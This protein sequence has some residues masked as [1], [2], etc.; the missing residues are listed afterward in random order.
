MATAKRHINF[1]G[2]KRIP[3]DAVEINLLET[4]PGSPPRATAKIELAKMGFPASAGV[5][6]EAYRSSS[7]MRFNC[8]TVGNLKIPTPLVLDEIDAG[9]NIQFRLK[10]T[11][12]ESVVGRLIAVAS[13]IQPKS[14]AGGE[15]RRSLL[16]IHWTDTLGPEIWGVEVDDDQ[17]PALQLNLRATGLDDRILTDPLLRGAIMPAAFRI[18][19]TR[20]MTFLPVDEE[21]ETDWKNDWLRFCSE[22]LG[23][24]D[25]PADL[26][27]EGRAEWVDNAVR[28]FARRAEFLDNVRKSAEGSG[29]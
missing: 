19:L 12:S 5:V 1:T 9:G 27:G 18:V 3:Q 8:G 7:L 17:P 11:D 14:D 28:T 6:V 2:R 29:E 16:P 20:L 4:P 23:I 13:R 15:G 26:D 24:K 25:D 21:D 22:E 10:V